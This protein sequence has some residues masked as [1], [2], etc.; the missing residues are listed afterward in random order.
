LL[1]FCRQGVAMKV[2]MILLHRL[3]FQCCSIIMSN[4]WQKHMCICH[5]NWEQWINFVCKW[6]RVYV[7][8]TQC[9]W[10]KYCQEMKWY[11]LA[12]T[13]LRG[14]REHGWCPTVMF[15]DRCY[16]A[17]VVEHI[18]TPF[19]GCFHSCCDQRCQKVLV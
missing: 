1:K 7:K 8:H 10:H 5:L 19:P 13:V 14:L 4:L 11:W 9:I 16:H 3:K 6:E 15:L 18:H 17:N 2:T 12:Q